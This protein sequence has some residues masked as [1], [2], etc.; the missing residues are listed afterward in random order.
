MAA[1][2]SL[3]FGLRCD[4]PSHSPLRLKEGYCRSEAAS[5]MHVSPFLERQIQQVYE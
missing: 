5:C 2:E 3:S 1:E 4:V